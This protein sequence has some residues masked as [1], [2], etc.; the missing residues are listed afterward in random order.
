MQPLL[1]T[2]G[3]VQTNGYAIPLDDGTVCVIDAPNG[4]S[5]WLAG[6]GLRASHLLI[7][8][9]HYDH[10]E[11]AA[12]LQRAGARVHAW[13]AYSKRLTLEEF[14]RSWGMPIEIEAFTVDEVL[15]GG[16]ALELPGVGFALAH[17]P[18]HALDAVNFHCAR[19]G[20]VFCGDTVFAGSIGRTDLPGGNHDLLIGGIRRHVLTLPPETRLFPGHGPDT[21]VRREAKSNP[22]LT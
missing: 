16:E 10:V 17:V 7:T 14:G 4:I 15:E 11:D 5:G 18:G 9:Q 6:R 3:F 2:G 8:H 20:V 12:A 21:T 1:Y 13:A 19:E 22:Y